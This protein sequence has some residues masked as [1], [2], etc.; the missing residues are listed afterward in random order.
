MNFVYRLFQVLDLI[1]NGGIKGITHIT[2]GGFT[3]NIPRVFPKGLG[4]DVNVGKVPQLN[5]SSMAFIPI[6]CI[7][8]S[9]G[10]KTNLRGS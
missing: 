5:I 10:L 3:D 8:I 2:G 1:A 4:G 9:A 6:G 7:R